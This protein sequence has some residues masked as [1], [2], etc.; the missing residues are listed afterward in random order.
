M[1]CTVSQDNRIVGER[2]E[3]LCDLKYTPG[4]ALPTTPGVYVVFCKTDYILNLLQQCGQKQDSKFIIVTHHSDYPVDRQLL[5]HTPLNVVKWYAINVTHQHPI[6]ESIPLGSASSTWIGGYEFAEVKD[7]PEF[8]LIEETGVDKQ[9]E[10]LVYMD[11]GIHTNPTHRREIYDYFK[12]KEWVTKKPCDI[13]IHEYEKSSFF[14]QMENYYA[15]MYNHKYVVSPL[16][17]GVDCGR[18]WQAIYLGTIPIIPRHININYYL[19]L[20]ILVYDDLSELTEQFLEDKYKEI[21]NNSNLEKSTMSY[22]RSE[23]RKEKAKHER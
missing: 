14:N 8:V 18:V 9:F 3:T 2:F 16:G 22:W 20:P 5:Q 1:R 17:N 6:L 7:S 19:D 13:P 10:N 11:F 21:F 12:D 15:S 23:I 4:S